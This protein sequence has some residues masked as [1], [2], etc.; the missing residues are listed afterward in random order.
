MDIHKY[1]Y[2]YILYETRT[3]IYEALEFAKVVEDKRSESEN[4]RCEILAQFRQNDLLVAREAR[5]KR[6]AEGTS[7]VILSGCDG[8]LY[9]AENK[10]DNAHDAGCSHHHRHAGCSHYRRHP[11]SCRL[12]S[13]DAILRPPSQQ[14]MRRVR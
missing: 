4:N 8:V 13:E 9:P 7:Q 3:F 12:R 6:R 5:R 10:E 2:A 11:C 14:R 1:V